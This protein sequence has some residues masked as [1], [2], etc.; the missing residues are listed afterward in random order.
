MGALH[1]NGAML[2]RSVRDQNYALPPDLPFAAIEPFRERMIPAAAL[3]VPQPLAIFSKT[4]KTH[5]SV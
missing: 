3:C 5:R 1:A 4:V 2:L